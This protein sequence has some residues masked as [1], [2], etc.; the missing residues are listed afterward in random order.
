M[1]RAYRIRVTESL[2]LDA[3]AEAEALARLELLPILGSTEM[4]ELLEAELTVS[5]FEVTNGTASRHSSAGL[6]IDVNLADLSLKVECELNRSLE[7]QND[8]VN[9]AG[10]GDDEQSV[11][12]QLKSE[13]Q[14]DADSERAALE[15][16]LKEEA[17]HVL[18][19]AVPE[20]RSEFSQIVNKVTANALKK[21]A[22]QLG[23]IQSVDD[24]GNG[25]VTIVVE[26]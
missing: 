4:C 2:Q 6:L 11:R 16:R 8:C 22:A 3:S 5:G 24:D 9:L 7:M 20:L 13:L 17:R 21:R 10:D 18:N 1:S 25:N 26:V 19:A 15:K 23:Q 12:K 14:Q